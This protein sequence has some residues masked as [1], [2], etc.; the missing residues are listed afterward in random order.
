MNVGRERYVFV[1]LDHGISMGA[2]DGLHDMERTLRAILAGPVDFMIV[3]KGTY[4][5]HSALFGPV[6]CFVNISAAYR[7]AVK[8]VLVSTPR[9]VV[10]MGA[11]GVSVHVNLGNAFEGD[12]LRDL[13]VVADQC[14]DLNVPLLAMMYHRSIDTGGQVVESRDPET[15]SHLCAVASEL[16]ADFVK[17]APPDPVAGLSEVTRSCPIPVLIAGG[18]KSTENEVVASVKEALDCGAAGVSFGR[19]VFQREDPAPLLRSI[20]TAIKNVE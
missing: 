17:I 7:Q 5:R 8:K 10:E 19:N 6:Q 12:M 9:E 4:R 3:N 18:A 20:A 1:A 2:I 14:A 11:Y 13:G 15:L 16:G